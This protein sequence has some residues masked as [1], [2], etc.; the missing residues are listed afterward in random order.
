MWSSK[1][2]QQILEGPSI[3]IHYPISNFG[4][5]IGPSGKFYKGPN[6]FSGPWGP[7]DQAPE[8]PW[9]SWNTS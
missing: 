2:P 8:S 7:K 4:G 6:G 1:G 3:E 9:G 5:F